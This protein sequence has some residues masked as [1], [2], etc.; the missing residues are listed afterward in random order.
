MR[1][2]VSKLS[3]S[4]LAAVIEQG[5]ERLEEVTAALARLPLACDELQAAVDT[6]NSAIMR[7]GRLREEI[8][9]LQQTIKP[10]RRRSPVSTRPAGEA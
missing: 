4:D 2:D 7:V 8:T 10:K 6:R 1:L 3:P 5:Q 9:S